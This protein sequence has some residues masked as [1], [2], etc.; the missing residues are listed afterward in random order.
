[1]RFDCFFPSRGTGGSSDS[2]LIAPWAHLGLLF[3]R[4]NILELKM[5]KKIEILLDLRGARRKLHLKH[6]LS[7]NENEP[8]QRNANVQP[9]T[10]IGKEKNDRNIFGLPTLG[11]ALSRFQSAST[12]RNIAAKT[13]PQTHR[14]VFKTR[15]RPTFPLQKG[16]YRD[17]D[18]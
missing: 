5:L 17:P 6:N 1:M 10:L 16:K 3:F 13:R 12:P 14:P 4:S 11:I 8:E 7:N 15:F 2:A 9:C 18:V